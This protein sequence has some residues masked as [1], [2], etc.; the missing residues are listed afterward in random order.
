[1]KVEE[2]EGGQC[3]LRELFG[4]FRVQRGLPLFFYCLARRGFFL[5]GPFFLR[6]LSQ[7]FLFSLYPVVKMMPGLSTAM[8]EKLVCPFFDPVP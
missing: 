1:L 6:N 5:A 7:D 2:R 3:L 4:Y 8:K